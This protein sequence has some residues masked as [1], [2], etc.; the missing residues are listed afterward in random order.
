MSA[1][2]LRNSRYA[3]L[4]NSP[5]LPFI[6]CSGFKSLRSI[7]HHP[8]IITLYDFFLLPSSKEL[9]FVFEAM[10]GN[11]HQL[12]KSRKGRPL[13]GGLVASIFHQTA[14]G[15]HHV[16]I[17]GYFH[18]DMRPENLLVTTTG[19]HDY[20]PVYPAVPPNAPPEKD[21]VVIIKL[22]D[23][24]LARE[25][26]SEPPYTEYVSVRWY[27]APEV[28]IRERGYSNPV[29]LWAFGVIMA[30]V[31]SLRPLF[32]GRGEVDQLARICDLLGDP[33]DEYG[34]DSRGKPLGGGTWP[35]GVE[36]ARSIGF[37]FPKVVFFH[38]TGSHYTML[39]NYQ[40]Q[41]KDVGSHFDRSV[42]VK[43]VECI[44]DLLKYDP[45]VRLTAQQCLEHPYLAETIPRND[46][47]SLVYGR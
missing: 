43:L 29:D 38:S 10:E 24:G 13:A 36:M 19:L 23:F 26:K 39:T 34:Q 30:E 33:S 25:T 45:D 22:A 46:P 28:L 18:R 6:P 9:H 14:S 31:V 21:V 35:R 20:L 40:V 12:I 2:K 17:S 27:R 42:P 5:P 4:N 37:M 1:K 44:T 32:P 15:L 41:P 47:P 16:H 7:P 11:L 8:N 3:R